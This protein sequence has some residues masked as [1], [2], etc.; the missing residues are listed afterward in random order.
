MAQSAD[1][2]PA[3]PPD[4]AVRALDSVAEAV[5]IAGADER[6]VYWNAAATALYGWSAAEAHGRRMS[7]LLVPADDRQAGLDVLDDLSDG[8]VFRGEWRMRHRDGHEL[9]VAATASAV[10]DADG[11]FRHFIGVSRDV[12]AEQE[13]DRR[14]RMLAGVVAQ[15]HDAVLTCDMAGIIGWAN[16]RV[17]EVFG[18][19]PADLVG[20]HLSELADPD[21]RDAQAA[22]VARVLAGESVPPSD[23]RRR[24][25]DGTPVD[26]NL[27]LV[28]IRDADGR[29]S[30]ISAVVRDLTVENALRR[31]LERQA[32]DLRAR[33][34]QAAT[35][36]TLMAMSGRFVAVNDA[37]CALLGH[38][39]EQLL[40]MNRTAL[41]HVADSGAADRT[42]VRLQ[43]GEL[44]SATF[45]RLLQ[46][47]DGHAIPVLVDITVLHGDDDTPYAMASFVRDLSRVSTAEQ[48][49]DRQQALYRALNQRASDVALVA[50]PDMTLRYVSPSAGDVFGYTEAEV[51]GRASWSFV[52]PDDVD[53]YRETVRRVLADPGGFERITVRIADRSGAWRWVE[54]SMTNAVA[55]PDIRGV[56]LNLREVTAEVQAKDELRRSEA[57][58]RAI[59]ETAQEGIIVFTPAGEVI[60]V[61]RKLAALMGRPLGDFLSRPP[62]RLFDAATEDLLRRKLAGRSTTGPETYEVPYLH[63]DGTW[64]T[65]SFSVAPLP[66]PDTDD[67]GSLAMVSDVTE[68]RHA[69]S[70]LRHRSAHDVLTDLPNRS[71]LVERIQE[72]L[73]RPRP[74]HGSI[75]LM[76]LDLDHFKLVNDSRGHDAG[77]LLLIEIGRRLRQAV[78]PEDTVARLGGDEFAVLCEDVDEALAVTIAGRLREA[79][80]RPVELGGPRVYVDASIGIA[81]SPP[82]DADTL[83]RFA[84]VAMYEAKASGRGRIRV[85]DSTLASSGERRLL[86]MNALREALDDDLLE[87]HYQPIVDI[88]S[89]RMTGVEA[90]LRWRHA[91][92]GPVSPLE[93]VDAADAMGLS[94]VLDRWVLRRACREMVNLRAAFGLGPFRLGVNV[95]ARSFA[96]PGLDETV[97]AAT[98]ETGWPTTDLTLEVTESA[99]MTDAPA[100]VRLL[101]ELKAQGVGIAVDD[102][103]TGYSSLAYL[104]RLPVTALK[105]D[106]SF[107]EQVTGDPDS[108]AIVRSIVQLAEALGLETVAEGIETAEMAAVMSDLGCSVGQGW[109]WSAAVPATELSRAAHG[110]PDRAAVG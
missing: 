50:D 92:L 35:P 83:L 22:A 61:N 20:R 21:R 66:L 91:D 102:F 73:H 56:V 75:A 54:K 8:G 59:A 10:R 62:A 78:R 104:K 33:F 79:L 43:A 5:I 13:A 47:R 11:V 64:H 100:A 44:R 101:G 70:V 107:T 69:E 36:Q 19:T 24:R 109:H 58:Y 51:I 68:A 29:L 106:R 63:P 9:T 16:D 46:H 99:I 40:Q 74:E 89:G 95:S 97:A 37:F 65:L 77:D 94:P 25:R 103:G 86:V 72:A 105:I 48:Q 1:R 17:A 60:F 53:G 76:F 67:L 30:G 18:W 80:G 81:L 3:P 98:T 27:A 2:P 45:E 41:A 88:D 55:D 12:S 52:H 28:P 14:T 93:V 6:I 90:L 85:F 110:W 34:E 4:L 82:H 87:L 15:S 26:V 49:L 7:Q 32:E 42:V 84:D 31:D 71:L 108:R 23:V 96:A 39:R 38:P 57:R